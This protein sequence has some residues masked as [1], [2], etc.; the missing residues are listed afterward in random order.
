MS[1]SLI[2]STG[3]MAD[4]FHH[5]TPCYRFRDTACD[6]PTSHSVTRASVLAFFRKITKAACAFLLA[7]VAVLA[8]IGALLM[9]IARACEQRG[10]SVRV[11]AETPLVERKEIR[12][13]LAYVRVLVNPNDWSAFERVMGVPP[14]GIGAKTVAQLQE[15]VIRQGVEATLA[16]AARQHKRLAALL[17]LLATLRARMG[18]PAATL[19]VLIDTLSYRAY[20]GR[21][22]EPDETQRRWSHVEEVIELADGW[23]C[24]HR[25]DIPQ[26][27]RHL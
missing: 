3:F 16:A 15:G 21:R 17:A 22:R 23:A 1:R 19:R 6:P 25:A 27:L 4:S 9:S 5:R 13:L 11:T 18:G 20:L 2:R 7:P 10:L 8:R 26:I 14:R 24:R 12:D